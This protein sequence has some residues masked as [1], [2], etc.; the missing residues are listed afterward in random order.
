MA[1]KEAW[2]RVTLIKEGNSQRIF[3]VMAIVGEKKKW[4]FQ[5]MPPRGQ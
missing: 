1:Y 2:K 5:A 3:G 4:T